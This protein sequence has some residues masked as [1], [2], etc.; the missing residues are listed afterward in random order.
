LFFAAASALLW[1]SSLAHAGGATVLTDGQL[2]GLTA[3]DAFTTG[4]ANGQSSGL[5]TAG[6]VQTLA[7]T[8]TGSNSPWGGSSGFS[9]AQ[10][11]SEGSNVSSPGSASTAATTSGAASGNFVSDNTETAQTLSGG[12]VQGAGWSFSAQ[13]TVV[14]GALVPGCGATCP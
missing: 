1:A 14:F 13:Y 12:P 9:S 8:T 4:T 11:F 5:Y 3:G 7:A 6:G 10:A 2:D